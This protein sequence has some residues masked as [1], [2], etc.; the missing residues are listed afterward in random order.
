MWGV[1]HAVVQREGVGGR[2]EG[3]EGEGG[4]RGEGGAVWK[5]QPFGAMLANCASA[6]K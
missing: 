1:K 5:S 4:W 2:G 3:G 6:Y